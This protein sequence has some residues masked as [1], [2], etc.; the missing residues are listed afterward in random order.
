MCGASSQANG[1][2]VHSA[3][4]HAVST[5]LVFYVPLVFWIQVLKVS[6]IIIFQLLFLEPI[7]VPFTYFFSPQPEQV[8][9]ASISRLSTKQN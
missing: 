6:I 1:V 8:L 2:G 3:V 4:T 9:P 5:R 7:Y